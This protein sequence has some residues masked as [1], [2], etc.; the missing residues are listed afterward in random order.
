MGQVS[1]ANPTHFAGHLN[2][3]RQ[4]HHALDPYWATYRGQTSSG[5]I[6]WS[7]SLLTPGMRPTSCR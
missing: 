3:G 4:A 7:W 1:C 5:A 2:R 6:A